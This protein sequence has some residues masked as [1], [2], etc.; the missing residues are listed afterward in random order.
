MVA[1]EDALEETM[2]R[3]LIDDQLDALRVA[4][5]ISLAVWTPFTD[6]ITELRA[7]LAV[8]LANRMQLEQQIRQAQRLIAEAYDQ[9]QRI[10]DDGLR[11]YAPLAAAATITT[12]QTAVPAHRP[13]RQ[14]ARPAT[15]A[16]LMAGAP[17][18][19]WWRTQ[20]LATQRAFAREVRLGFIK[21]EAT[22]QIAARV[23][24]TTASP[25]VLDTTRRQ[26]RQLVHTSL[27]TLANHVREANF[28]ANPDI[29]RGLK[30]LATLDGRTCLFC[31]ARDGKAYSLDHQPVGHT[32]AWA[33]GPGACHFGCRCVVVPR[34]ATWRELGIDLDEMPPGTRASQDGQ[35]TATLT[36]ER[37]LDTKSKSFQ[38]EYFGP[39]RAALWREGHL[40]LSELLDMRGR[41]LSVQA[42]R[43]RIGPTTT[44]SG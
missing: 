11:D 8:P 16:L 19:E 27:Q 17:S 40:T 35:V 13:A 34:L 21:G 15:S 22:E 44:A 28:Q 36:F 18:H 42:L 25:G 20:S 26:A 23:I 33:G 24:G 10:L 43:D 5:A 31:G 6:L 38:D 41:P 14:A 3:K 12:L 9:A 2:A 30:W 7:L 1:L 29:V 32:L 4:A 37:W 39:G